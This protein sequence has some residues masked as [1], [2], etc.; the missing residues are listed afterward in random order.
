MFHVTFVP[1]ASKNRTIS[2]ICKKYAQGKGRLPLLR[3]CVYLCTGADWGRSGIIRYST[4]FELN[5]TWSGAASAPPPAY[6]PAHYIFMN[7]C[8]W[9]TAKDEVW[10]VIKVV[11]IKRT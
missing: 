2:D 5:S 1:N 6:A 10:R 9:G 3:I 11:S 8:H 7:I 4:H